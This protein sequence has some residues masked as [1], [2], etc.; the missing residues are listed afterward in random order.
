MRI[1]FPRRIS[2]CLEQNY[3]SK[4]GIFYS[5]IRATALSELLNQIKQGL[6][7]GINNFTYFPVDFSWL[8]GML[9]PKIGCTCFLGQAGENID[10]IIPGDYFAL[11]A[12]KQLLAVDAR[13]GLAIQK[14]AL[15]KKEFTAMNTC[16]RANKIPVA[17]TI[18]LKR[19]WDDIYPA[20]TDLPVAYL[21]D[22]YEW[23]RLT[24]IYLDS[25]LVLIA[26][27]QCY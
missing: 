19:F 7:T 15:V 1:K 21:R 23:L 22:G 16:D 14:T 20:I 6:L 26:A 24:N 10:I 27:G 18:D 2:S 5:F 4:S 3:Q 11:V 17:A 25:K 9:W 12:G 8:A 13:D